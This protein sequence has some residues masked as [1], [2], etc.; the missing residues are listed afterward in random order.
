MLVAAVALSGCESGAPPAAAPTASSAAPTVTPTPTPAVGPTRTPAPTVTPSASPSPSVAPVTMTTRTRNGRDGRHRWTAAYPTLHGLGA[1]AAR[2]A[3]AALT[4]GVD[5][6]VR[7]D[8]DGGPSSTEVTPEVWAVDDVYVTVRVSAY[9]YAEGAAHGAT[10]ITH[11]VLDR[12][13]GRRLTLPDLL[14]PGTR[15]AALRAMSAFTRR[16][17]PEVIEVHDADDGTAPTLANYETVTPLPEGLEVTFAEY[18]V[19]SYAQGSPTMTVPWRVLQ[20]YLAVRLPSGD[21]DPAYRDGARA[22]KAV[23]DAAADDP[24]VGRV[25]LSRAQVAQYDGQWAVATMPGG[26]RVALRSTNGRWSVAEVGPAA[27]CTAFPERVRR[28][29]ALRCG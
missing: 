25:A 10:L 19:A 9:F 13:T 29:L 18:Q 26:D 21:R 4:A 11:Y 14:K 8:Y 23:L 6:A 7:S 17:L 12:A 5:A 28:S 20:P 1:T 24:R 3:N 27:G 2:R 16:R 22:G 15:D